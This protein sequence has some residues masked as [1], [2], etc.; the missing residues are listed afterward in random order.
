MILPK[1]SSD[2]INA[3]KDCKNELYIHVMLKLM[4]KHHKIQSL[5]ADRKD[6]HAG[7]RKD[8]PMESVVFFVSLNC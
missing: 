5:G 1:K 3:E 4:S 6:S 7:P 2:P 8:S